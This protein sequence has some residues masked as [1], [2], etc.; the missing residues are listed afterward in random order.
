MSISSL[1]MPLLP[2]IA[3]GLFLRLTSVR[4]STFESK[5]HKLLLQQSLSK[6]LPELPPLADEGC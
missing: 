3:W 4:F 2:P 1:M 5:L 6:V